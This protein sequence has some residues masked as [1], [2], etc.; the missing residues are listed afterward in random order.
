VPYAGELVDSV[1]PTCALDTRLAEVRAQLDG[2]RYG[3]CLVVTARRILLGRIRRRALTDA[4][5]DATAEQVMESGPSTV[6]FNTPAGELVER[7]V[8]RELKTA[9]VT[10]PGGMLLGVFHREDAA[11]RLEGSA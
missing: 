11:A 5:D 4:E 2:S 6:R 9:I 3:F 1:P 7:L 8:K 10:T